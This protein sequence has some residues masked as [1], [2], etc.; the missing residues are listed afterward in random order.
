MTVRIHTNL[1]GVTQKKFDTVHK[2]IIADDPPEGLICHSS[3]P[4]DGGWSA[5]DFWET[6]QDYDAGMGRVQEATA[7]A[8]VTMHGPSEVE[9][10]SVYETF[11]L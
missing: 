11:Q 3:A 1:V 5:I 10:F 8:G 6:R 4:I 2:L 9:E 7:T